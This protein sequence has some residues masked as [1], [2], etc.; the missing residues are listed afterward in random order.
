MFRQV[1]AVIDRFIDFDRSLADQGTMAEMIACYVL[2]TYFL[3]A[4]NVTGFLW[5]N[6]DRGSGKTQLLYVICQMAYLGQVLLAGGSFAALRDLADYGACLAFDDA[7]NV[8][9]PAKWDPD[10]RALLLAGNRRGATVAVKEPTGPRGWQTRYVSAFCPRLFSAIR[11]PDPVLASRSI[12]VPLIRTPDRAAR[13]NADALDFKQWP[14][15]RRAIVDALWALALAH[16][17]K[18]PDYDARVSEAASSGGPQP[19]AVAHDPRRGPLAGGPGVSGLFRRLDRLSVAYQGERVALEP[20]NRHAVV[21]AALW[22]LLEQ[23]PGQDRLLAGPTDIAAAAAALVR[24]EQ[25]E[26]EPSELTPKSVGR[27]LAAMRLAR[28]R[29]PGTGKRR[30]LIERAA[31][32]RAMLAE[33]L[34]TSD[35]TSDTANT[36]KTEDQA[37]GQPG[38]VTDVT[39]VTHDGAGAEDAPAA[40]TGAPDEPRA[41]PRR[42]LRRAGGR[43]GGVGRHV[44]RFFKSPLT[45]AVGKCKIGATA[46]TSGTR[47]HEAP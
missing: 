1:A 29:D 26:I 23:A 21:L 27:A 19:A 5:P 45:A 46:G 11:L 10:K 36:G 18:L 31:V 33:G 42:R 6:G 37:A 28:A 39:D 38:S 17:P 24:R 3:P 25:Y 7:E 41:A 30:W 16:L 47:S 40:A 13:A 15:D 2:G 32:I 20:E 22:K 44:G 4:F 34:L 14:H 8:S 35:P 9:N 12:I 43:V